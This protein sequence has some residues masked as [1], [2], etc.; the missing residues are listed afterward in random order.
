MG[1]SR[2]RIAPGKGHAGRR[3]FRA[4]SGPITRKEARIFRTSS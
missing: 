1:R 2:W 4:E 3:L